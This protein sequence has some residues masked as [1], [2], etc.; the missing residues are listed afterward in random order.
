MEKDNKHPQDIEEFVAFV[1]KARTGEYSD[2]KPSFREILRCSISREDVILL[3]ND[4][5]QDV[6]MVLYGLY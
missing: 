1:E 4:D 3:E 5:V 2:K 6:G